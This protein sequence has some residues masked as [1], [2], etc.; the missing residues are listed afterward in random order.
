M[1]VTS[2]VGI[3]GHHLVVESGTRHKQGKYAREDNI[4]QFFGMILVI[5][6]HLDMPLII[7]SWYMKVLD[8]KSMEAIQEGNGQLWAG[9]NAKTN[10]HMVI[11]QW[12]NNK[13]IDCKGMELIMGLYSPCS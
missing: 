4:H 8:A 3:H 11:M 13:I 2:L 6:L 5:M 1:L 9:H 7:E 12:V 10:P